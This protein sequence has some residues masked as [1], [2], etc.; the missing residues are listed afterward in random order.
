MPG[1]SI[2]WRGN[3]FNEEEKSAVNGFVSGEFVLDTPDQ[4][5]PLDSTGMKHLT[6]SPAFPI[7][8]RCL[9][10]TEAQMQPAS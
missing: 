1:F 5:F 7:V 2:I 3:C 4:A 6:P 9:H 10:S 8:I